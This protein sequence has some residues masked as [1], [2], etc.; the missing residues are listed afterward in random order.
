MMKYAV[1]GK[2]AALF[3][4][5]LWDWIAPCDTKIDLGVLFGVP[6]HI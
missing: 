6:G 5:V 2:I 4:Q 3:G 1:I